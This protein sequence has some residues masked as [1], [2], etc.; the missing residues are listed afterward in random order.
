MVPVQIVLTAAVFVGALLVSSFLWWSWQTR[1]DARQQQLTMRVGS[2]MDDSRLLHLREADEAIRGQGR[3]R[4]HLART[5]RSAGDERKPRDLLLM[6]GVMAGAGL[7]LSFWVLPFPGA[8]A[9]ALVGLAPYLAVA[10]EGRKRSQKLT[11][12][13]PD[14]LDLVCRALRAGRAFGDALRLA[15]TELPAPVGEE[16][17]QVSEEHRLGIDLRDCLG[18]LLVRNPKNWDLRLFV[19]SALLQRETGGNLIE[20]L[21]HLAETVRDRLIFESKVEALTA[22]VRF[23][24]WVLGLLPFLVACLLLL[25][26]PLYLAPLIST[27]LGRFMLVFG[28]LSLSVGAVTMRRLAQLEAA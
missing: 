25:V 3:W 17:V 6:M 21:E 11:E 16:L 7:F 12:Q 14:A 24:A 19:G 18:N 4:T 23:S 10:R 26:Q 28:V 13:L 2:V 1:Q 9:G 22:E 20:M 27:Q 15:A 8:L 5:L